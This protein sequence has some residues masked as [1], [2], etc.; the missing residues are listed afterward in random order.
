MADISDSR[1]ISQLGM[2]GMVGAG[3]PTV[4]M[5]LPLLMAG[6]SAGLTLTKDV[7]FI[8]W[9]RKKLRRGFWLEATRSSQVASIFISERAPISMPPVLPGKLGG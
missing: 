8:L 9:A 3:S 6:I 7:V 4:A 2:H 1:F 5:T